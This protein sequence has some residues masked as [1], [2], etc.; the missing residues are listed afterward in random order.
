ML[1]DNDTLKK[2]LVEQNYLEDSDIKQAEAKM[3]STRY[4]DFYNFLIAENLMTRDLI[5]QAMAEHYGVPYAD[6]NSQIPE[7]VLF[8]KI[9]EEVSRKYR[10]V[11]FKDSDKILYVA[12]DDPKQKDLQKN[13]EA[14]LKNVKVG[15][16][17]SLPEDISTIFI[18][19]QRP[20]ETRFSKILEGKTRIAP[21]IIDEIISD[22]IGFKSSDIHLEPS[23]EI[24]LI[25]F[26]V[27][28]VLKEAGT[29]PKTYY[30]N[31]IN[32]IKVQASLRT[33][34]HNIAQDG[35]V[36][37]T[38]KDGRQIDLRISV[39]P[40]VEGEKVAIR[41][42]G[43]YIR[44]FTLGDLGLSSK[45][46]EMI[47]TTAELPF[48]MI[49][50]T[51][52]TGSGKSTTLYALLKILNSP[53]I[54]IT[55]IEDPVEYKIQGINQIQVNSAVDLTFARGL[56]SIV[57]QDPDV[58]LVGEIR[59]TE[60]AEIAVNASLT[61]HLLLSTFHANDASTAI[62]RLLDMG[63]EPFLLASTLELIVAQR[64]VRKICDQC[65][66][67]TTVTRDSIVA[68][69]K[70]L[71]QIFTNQTYT[72]Y[73]G[74]GCENCGGSGY[75]GRTA[76]FEFIKM[77]PEMEDLTLSHPSGGQVSAL[78]SSQGMTPMFMDG[79]EK[80]ISGVTTIA[81]LLRVVQPPEDK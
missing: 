17:Y 9:P 52:P 10:A 39:M 31:I 28:G 25:R 4:S 77:T 51:G 75:D 66:Y 71:A 26:R 42:L 41:L 2:I 19:Y 47:K 56:R 12:T 50:V 74:K 6:L 76:I 53:Q 5:G 48:G 72:L 30:D 43:E 32:R 15:L 55:T 65:R 22:A 36:R 21:E 67:S 40:T 7:K 34:E 70:Y 61:G 62:P 24:V 63:I 18:R 11:A 59:D 69:H 80:V 64:L 35:S 44:D 14:V 68:R 23:G 58:I 38:T 73:E 37:H 49:L 27:D 78:A 57:R 60:T 13:L 33:D 81:E 45:H 20:L 29:L 1:I 16:M 46:E 54:N 8:E 79:I 3:T